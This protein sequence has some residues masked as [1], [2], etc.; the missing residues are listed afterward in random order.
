MPGAKG[1]IRLWLDGF[2]HT[3][4]RRREEC[5]TL[6]TWL[7]AG[8]GDRILDIGCGDG[9]YDARM[10]RKGAR[11]TGIDIGERQ[12]ARAQ[13]VYNLEGLD[14][15]RV[16][17]ESAEFESGSYNKAVSFCVMEHLD[18]DEAVMRVVYQA[19]KPGGIFCFSADSLS[20]PGLREAERRR[21]RSRYA[22]NTFYTAELI[23][24]K[25]QRCGFCLMHHHYIL[26]DPL[27]LSLVRFS[28]GLDR[29]P[30][31]LMPL[32]SV[33]YLALDGVTRLLSCLGLFRH[34]GHSTRSGLTLLV[35]AEKGHESVCS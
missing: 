34:Q 12:V 32:K 8:P 28:W 21:H 15:R 20:N 35:R 3:N 9:Y 2:L 6:L 14:F 7:D 18:D 11:V 30:P 5:A 16:P 1:L 19:L 29:L 31:W 33:G 24:G 27:S 22:V 4:W 17:A 13:R 10:Q 23:R 25:L 26:A